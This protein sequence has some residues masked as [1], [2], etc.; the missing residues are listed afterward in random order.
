MRIIQISEERLEE[1]FTMAIAEIEA[2]LLKFP[3]SQN[4]HGDSFRDY[5][6]SCRLHIFRLKDKVKDAI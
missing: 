3:Q 4:V 5:Q 2:D 6:R 1:L